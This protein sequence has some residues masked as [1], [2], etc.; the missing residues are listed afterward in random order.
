MQIE[1]AIANGIYVAA[2][3]CD[4]LYGRDGKFL[5]GL[6][7]L[8]QTFVAEV[9]V[10]FHGWEQ[11]PKI[12]RS[13]PKNRRG[14]QKKYPRLARRRPSSEVRNLLTYSPVFQEQSWQKYHIKDTN[15]GPQVWEVKWT[16]FWRKEGGDGLPGRRH[17]LIVARNVLTEEIKYF[18]VNGVPGEK[19]VT[20][21]WLLS[22][23]FR[24]CSVEQCFREAKEELGMN[25][26]EVRGWRCVHRHY[27]VAQLSQLFCARV[28]QEYDDPESPE[29]DRLTVEQVRTAMNVW[30]S[31]ADTTP[32][33]QKERYEQALEK[34]RY[35][36][37]RNEQ[38][39]KSHTKTKTKRL[40]AS[41]I[42]VSKIKSC[43]T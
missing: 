32:A 35:H 3:T 40:N 27:Y 38:A 28:R 12:L 34:Q 24:R 41:G 22:V 16:I 14:K 31:A 6:E 5:D 11:K 18:V 4:E 1:H 21:R 15:K 37:R 23:A 13:G 7:Q 30:L 29:Q 39:R 42:D 33:V 10:D 19:G 25:H 17:C 26:F 8:N 36:Q 2:W 43:V 9:P 20:L